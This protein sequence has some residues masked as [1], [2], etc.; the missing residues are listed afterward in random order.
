MSDFDVIDGDNEVRSI[1]DRPA[2]VFGD[3]AEGGRWSENHGQAVCIAAISSDK[4]SNIHSAHRTTTTFNAE[5]ANADPGIVE[6]H[7]LPVF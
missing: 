3:H 5:F 6:V 1:E 4:N 2:E 7:F